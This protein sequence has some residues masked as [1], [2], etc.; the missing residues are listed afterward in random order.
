M[1]NATNEVIQRERKLWARRMTPRWEVPSGKMTY[2]ATTA[3]PG[4]STADPEESNGTARYKTALSKPRRQ[5]CQKPGVET[6]GC[7]D[8]GKKSQSKK[9]DG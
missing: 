2:G 1:W 6:K 4:G 3:R 7:Q 9:T 8:V 5:M